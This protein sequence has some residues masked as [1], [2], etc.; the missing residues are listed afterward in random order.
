[1]MIFKILILIV[2]AMIIVFGY[3]ILWQP[4]EPPVQEYTD[5][6]IAVGKPVKVSSLAQAGGWTKE[7]LV[8]GVRDSI[9]SSAKGWSSTLGIP[10]GNRGRCNEW[11]EIDTGD[12]YT[13]NRVDIYPRNDA[14]YIGDGFPLNFRI[15]VS[16]DEV[17]WA[18]TVIKTD[19]VK[20]GN[21]VQSFTFT[22]INAR[23][24]RVVG[25][26]LRTIGTDTLMQFAE[27]EIYRAL[28]NVTLSANIE[29]T[30]DYSYKLYVN[31]EKIGAGNVQTPV[32][33]VNAIFN[34]G[35]NVIAV[36]V[37]S[38]GDYGGLLGQ[39]TIDG[40]LFYTT[41]SMW[42]ISSSADEGW[43]TIDFDDNSWSYATDHGPYGMF[44]WKYGIPDMSK[45]TMARW[46]W[47]SDIK[48]KERQYFRYTVYVDGDTGAVTAQQ[49]AERIQPLPRELTQQMTKNPLWNL[50]ENGISDV[51]IVKGIAADTVES[52][53]ATEL[54]SYLGSMI[55]TKPSIVTT[56]D[57]TKVNI[58][59]G[60]PSSNEYIANVL[61]NTGT[62]I[63]SESH[64]YDGYII[65][66]GVYS[67]YKTILL[68]GYKS[69]STLFASYYLLENL[70]C[71]FLGPKT[72]ALNEIIPNSP[73]LT[74]G[75]LNETRVPVTKFRMMSNGSYYASDT[76]NLEKMADWGAKS[77]YNSILLTLRMKDPNGNIYDPWEPYDP[78]PLT[79]RGI[80]I[81]MAGHNWA[82][83][84]ENAS[85]TWY[86]EEENIQKFLEKVKQY[87]IGHPEAAA[88]GAWQPDGPRGQIRI[89]RNGQN[90][91]FTEWNLYIMNRIAE[92]FKDNNIEQR[93][94][95]MAYVEGN[96]PP[97]YITPDPLIDLYYYH[98]WQNYQAPLNSEVGD[99]P[100]DWIL[101]DSYRRPQNSDWATEPIP[102]SLLAQRP[103]VVAWS[104]YLSNINF[105]GDKVLVDHISTGIGIT[106][107]HPAISFTTLGPVYSLE[108]DRQ[109]E[110]EQGFNGYTNCFGHSDYSDNLTPLSPDPYL[111]RRM[112]EALWNDLD[113]RDV[114]DS[115]Y[116]I[117]YYGSK[118]AEQIMQFFDSVYFEILADK[119]DYYSVKNVMGS[120]YTT[121]TD[122]RA[123]IINDADITAEQKARIEIAYNWYNRRVIPY[124]LQYY[125][126]GDFSAGMFF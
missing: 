94:M 31:G 124:K 106:L 90:W 70:G 79:K 103:V 52:F 113:D 21:T 84:I 44:P 50:A 9:S 45:D 87:A 39:I 82:E 41:N 69:R 75:D 7:C 12:I 40:K 97:D 109:Y 115:D 63:T 107:K 65:K 81:M 72:V 104:N 125:N 36:E 102:D 37:N 6:N 117:N 118:Y 61:K 119:R 1:M 54:Q 68:T 8:D 55:G 35:I 3:S 71:R 78:T 30:A 46:I 59:L 121:I 98:Q 47:N 126:E 120:L 13:I 85:G 67:E 96:R 23:Y 25:T 114:L 38:I 91:R 122:L 14:G 101:N 66:T 15:Q 11:V 17:V 76:A 80:E 60:T 26:T 111:Y 88:I 18:D 64:G 48:C 43:N 116:Y 2:Y 49:P 95:W 29:M 58:L 100:V 92:M 110:R 32:R 51:V 5:I 123:A 33:P 10:A 93:V 28:P 77:G 24:V 4:T 20:P 86:T 62:E 27:I 16:E 53:A 105:Q 42:K 22:P 74:V 56:M 83:F 73:N 34:P 108:E 57:N 99:A 112:S 19:Y 89:D